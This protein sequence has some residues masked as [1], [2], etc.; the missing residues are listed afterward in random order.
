MAFLAT[1]FMLIKPA[2]V[3]R[4]TEA[5]PELKARL[6]DTSGGG[7]RQAAMIFDALFEAETGQHLSEDYAFC[8]RWRDLGGQ[9]FA[10]FQARLTDVGHAAYAGSLMDAQAR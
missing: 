6:G 1:G 2:V 9:V 5:H 4:V 10:D 3:E 7:T 8:R